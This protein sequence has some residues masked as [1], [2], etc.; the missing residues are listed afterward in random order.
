MLIQLHHDK[1]DPRSTT[2]AFVA[3]GVLS[4]LSDPDKQLLRART[5]YCVVPSE[6]VLCDRDS[7]EEQIYFPLRGVV[8]FV[9]EL[10]DGKSIASAMIGTGGTVGSLSALG[11]QRSFAKVVVDIQLQAICIPMPRLLEI[12]PTTPTLKS[13]LA[14]DAEKLIRHLLQISAC[15][16]LHPIEK[17]VARVLLQAA[18]CIDNNVV[19]L[20]QERMAQMLGAQRTTV[21]LVLNTMASVGVVRTNRGRVEI[22]D[23]SELQERACECYADIHSTHCPLSVSQR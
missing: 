11:L 18:D 1:C 14:R 6:S 12:L 5:R 8:S 7:G 4:T 13:A 22:I 20:T 16:A 9:T 3:N 15:A 19:P 23:R 21:N 2:D 10:P 17:R